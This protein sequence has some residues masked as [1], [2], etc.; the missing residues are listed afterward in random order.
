MG[1]Y[2]DVGTSRRQ[3]GRL[4]P[5]GCRGEVGRVVRAA[6]GGGRGPRRRPVALTFSRVSVRPGSGCTSVWPQPPQR[7]T[8]RP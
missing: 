5:A 1:A 7:G 6:P 4:G 2:C 3:V 8:P